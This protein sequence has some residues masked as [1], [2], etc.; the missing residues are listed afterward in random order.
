[1]TLF[2]TDGAI[3]RI[4]VGTSRPLRDPTE[5]RILFV[6][7]LAALADEFDPGFGFDMARLAVVVAEPWHDEQSDLA[8]DAPSHDDNDTL[9]RLV[10]RLSV[11]LGAQRVRRLAAQDSHIPELAVSAL[12]AQ[13]A[14]DGIGWDTFRHYRAEH[15]IGPR[16]LRM[17]MRPEPIETV[18]E[19]PDGPPLRFRWRRALHEVAAAEGPER[20]EG[21]WWTATDAADSARD[22]FCVEDKNGLR[23]WLFRAGLY[24]NLSEDDWK[25]RRFPKWYMHGTFM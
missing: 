3:R 23:F 9:A 1:L 24:R 4:G 10:D 25:T 7:R 22:Y 16:P 8:V 18:A 2:R 12:P 20:I 17:L 13:T 19:V 11:R 5:I 14:C 21:T 6:G 15:G